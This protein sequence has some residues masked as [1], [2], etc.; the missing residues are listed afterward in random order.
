MPIGALRRFFYRRLKGGLRQLKTFLGVRPVALSEKN[1]PFEKSLRR[2]ARFIVFFG[3]QALLQDQ[4]PSFV[5][6][7]ET[8]RLNEEAEARGAWR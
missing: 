8:S 5:T 4:F 7:P 3:D 1:I 2:C 6:A